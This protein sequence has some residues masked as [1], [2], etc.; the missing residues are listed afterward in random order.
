VRALLEGPGAF[1][2]LHF[3]GHGFAA[4]GTIN[5]PQIMLQ[6]ELLPNGSYQP[7]YLKADAVE[8]RAQ[9]QG[10]D[11]NRPLVVLNA[12]Q[13]GRATWHLTGIGGFAQ[14][15]LKRGAGAFIG[16]LWSVGD[17]PARHFT[18]ALYAALKQGDDM[19]QAARKARAT[20]RMASDAT[21]LSYAVYAHP[22]ARF[23]V[24]T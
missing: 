22:H 9:L 14:A 15:F 7:N 13:A 1:D 20:A 2:L 16:T 21:W 4:Q 24:E 3:A 19:A 12:C 5:E 8:S 10:A 6:G 11:G 23:K 18:E 17:A